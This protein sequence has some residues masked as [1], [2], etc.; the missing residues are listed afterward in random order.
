MSE[1]FIPGLRHHI[2]I[3]ELDAN[4]SRSVRRHNN[5]ELNYVNTV[6]S[7]KT[8]RKTQKTE[9]DKDISSSIKAFSKFSVLAFEE[10]AMRSGETVLR[11]NET[12]PEDL[13][14]KHDDLEFVYKK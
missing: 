9:E 6:D 10:A 2:E 14:E 7:V 4:L 5:A 8:A 13:Q 1:I 11:S 3:D 12:L